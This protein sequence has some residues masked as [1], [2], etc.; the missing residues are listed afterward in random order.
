MPSKPH[1]DEPRARAQGAADLLA[2]VFSVATLLGCDAM[3]AMRDA[4]PA[5]D[6]SPSDGGGDP[7]DAG[8]DGAMPDE[9]GGGG[10]PR[11]CVRPDGADPTGTDILDGALGRATVSID[12]R[13]ACHRTYTM[14]STATL[15]DGEP[16]NPRSFPEM[17]GWPTVRSGHD[18]FDALYAL[19]VE[20]SRELSVSTIRDG[21]FDDG[22]AVDCGGCFETGRLWNYVWTRDTAYAV[23]LGMAVVD[24]TRARRS[25]EF[26]L[27]ERRG[28]GDLQIVQDTGSGGSYPISSDR[29]SWAVGAR[30][31][32]NRLDGAERDAF[33]DLA[34]RAISN[35]LE[36]DRRIVHDPED[37]LYRGEQSFLDWREQT[38]PE[39]TADDVVHIG[40]SKALGT[41][42][43]HFHAMELAA[44]LADETGDATRRDRYRGWAD[45]LRTAIRARFWL[46]DEGLFSTFV[47][48]GLDPAP[49]RR[50]DLLGSAFAVIFGVADAS[51]AARI[52]ESYPHYGPGAPVVWPQQQAT[53]IYHNRGE[54]PFVS[55]YWLRAAKAAGSGAVIDRMVAS[56][57]RGAALNLSN[58]ENFE[59]G[60]GAPWLD[61]GAAS[62]PVVNSQRQLWSV[63]GYLSTVHHTIFGLEAEADGLHVRPGLTAEQ[64]S[65]LFGGTNEIVLNDYPYRGRTVTVVIHLPDPGGAGVLAVDA[66]ELNGAALSGD[67]LEGLVD[68]AN[69]VDV[70]LGAG[71]GASTL[72]EV[73]DADWQNVFGPRTPRITG[74]SAAGGR[75]RLSLSTSEASDVTWRIY[76]DGAVV[77]DDLPG[78]TTSWDDPSFDPASP[79]SPCYTAELT[80]TSSGNHSQHA[81]PECWWGPGAARV[82]TIDASAMMNVG[83]SGSTSHG[84]FHYEPWGDPGDSLTVPSFTPAQTGTHLLQVTFGNG[85]GSI[86]TGITCAVKRVVVEEVATGTIVAEGPLLMPHLGTWARWE[87]SS[88]VRADLVAGTA[89]RIVI[90]GDEEMVNMSSFAHFEIYTGGLGGRSGAFNRANIADLKILAL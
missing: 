79:R 37:G 17:N 16:E 51:Q 26:K 4:A 76:R 35:T 39:Y 69:R 40:M 36:H 73:S 83:G 84:R 44:E 30:A 54:W 50:Y 19:A 25:M 48:T 53:P 41:N 72:T 74:I 6:A 38:Y 45:E 62:G 55:A 49:V 22:R 23:D 28:G 8:R 68:G 81:P 11:T 9:D 15:R 82:T 56:M 89:Y 61:D 32:L 29:V 34:L 65:D 21:A 63:A 5:D 3:P 86:N 12:D 47:P 80:F 67:L 18:L 2:V 46:E 31:L 20:E 71:G 66:I 87:D 52:L 60:S 33:R 14:T 1:I 75:L 85:A 43:L 13:A 88:F 70:T 7:T 77:A 90:R 78:T 58:M 24:P 64:R 59:A 10:P 42:L 27:S 57:M